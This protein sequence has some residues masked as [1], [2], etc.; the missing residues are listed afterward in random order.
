M[1]KTTDDLVVQL[2]GL[3]LDK[4]QFDKLSQ[5]LRLSDFVKFAKYIPTGEDDK[6]CYEDIKKSIM[7]L[8]QSGS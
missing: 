5:S 1:Q 3:N 6:T 8:E 4:N 7:T 2:K